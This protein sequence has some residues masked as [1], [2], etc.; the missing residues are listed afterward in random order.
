MDEPHR[1]KTPL[2]KRLSAKMRRDA[3]VAAGGQ[4]YADLLDFERAH[5]AR[6]RQRH[7]EKLRAEGRKRDKGRSVKSEIVRRARLRGRKAG[8]GGTITSADI[9]WPTHCPVLGLELDYTPR[10]Q[11]RIFN[12]PANPTL[13]RW[14]N[15]KGYVPGNVFVISWRA[16]TLKNNATWQELQAVMRYARDGLN[17]MRLVA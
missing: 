11:G 13:D 5:R 3:I 12:N 10:G 14:D 16:N 7:R 9:V 1:Y 17:F 4:A 8:M 6:Y 2:R 15:S